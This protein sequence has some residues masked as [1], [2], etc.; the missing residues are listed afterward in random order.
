MYLYDRHGFQEGAHADFFHY[1]SLAFI[2]C[3]LVNIGSRSSTAEKKMYSLRVFR[4][5][6]M[7]NSFQGELNSLISHDNAKP[8]EHAA[9]GEIEI[10]ASGQLSV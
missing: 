8:M 3:T 10:K 5:H 7:E 4:V 6:H 1:F 2:R 9:T